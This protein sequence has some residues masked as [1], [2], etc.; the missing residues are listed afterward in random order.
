MGDMPTRM[1]G[2]NEQF[3]VG[4]LRCGSDIGNG[5]PQRKGLTDRKCSGHES[6]F[7]SRSCACVIKG[8]TSVLP[9][10]GF[11]MGPGRRDRRVAV[12]ADYDALCRL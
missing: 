4:S 6:P 10:L 9:H 12:Q 1:D 11:H 8:C 7:I 2:R 5:I 3:V